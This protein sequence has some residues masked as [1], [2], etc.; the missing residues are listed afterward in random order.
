MK[1][2]MII[3]KRTVL[4]ISDLMRRRIR[5]AN[6]G[7]N[8]GNFHKKLFFDW[9]FFL[10]ICSRNYISTIFSLCYY[11][12]STTRKLKH[13]HHLK[14]SLLNLHTKFCL[15]IF[16]RSKT[17]LQFFQISSYIHQI[18][19]HRH[20]QFFYFSFFNVWRYAWNDCW[21]SLSKNN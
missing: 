5:W 3:V 13:L 21:Y 4:M 15:I 19:S 12:S 16:S 10:S 18:V 20:I 8:P 17:N 6:C 7:G 9:F 2:W 11:N 14:C 1:N